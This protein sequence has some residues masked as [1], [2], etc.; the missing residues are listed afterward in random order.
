MR[1]VSIIKDS[2]QEYEDHHSL[3]LF[4]KGCNLN[5]NGCY[6][7]E[8]INV[9]DKRTEDAICII[10]RNITPIHDS[11]V[12]LGGEP[13]IWKEDL[14]NVLSYV[15]KKK[16]KTK[17]YTNG[18]LPHIVEKINDKKLCNSWSVDFK[19]IKN[20]SNVLGVINLS[21]LYLDSVT[22]TIQNIVKNKIPLEIRTTIWKSNNDQINDIKKYVKQ[23]FKKVNHIIQKDFI[24]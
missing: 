22:N 6:N 8:S 16:L 7:K 10:N 15:K 14:I 2:F 1:I 17:I 13:T 5:C 18:M 20:F 4:S 3:V 23:N 12:F 19:C 21:G 9:E 24:V 11:I